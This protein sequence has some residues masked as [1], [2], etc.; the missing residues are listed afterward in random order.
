[1]FSEQLELSNASCLQPYQGNIGESHYSTF[2]EGGRQ[3]MRKML[4]FLKDEN[5]QGMVEYGLIIALIAVVVIA[6]L[7]VL[8]PAIRDLFNDVNGYL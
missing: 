2:M 3:I 7:T 1:M 8:G 4:D 5:G 6:A